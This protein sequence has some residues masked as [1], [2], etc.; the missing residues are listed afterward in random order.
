MMRIDVDFNERDRLGHVRTRV[1]AAIVSQLTVGQR[2]NLYD[3]P[4]K[5]WADAVVSRINQDTRIVAFDVD[6][7]SFEDAEVADILDP[8]AQW[9]IGVP[10]SEGHHQ[11]TNTWTS[12]VSTFRAAGFVLIGTITAGTLHITFAGRSSSSDLSS[13]DERVAA[14]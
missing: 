11:L 7:H 2:V 3:P 14:R 10:P 9:S 5:L 13:P 1:P 6:W 8:H 12:S 4:E